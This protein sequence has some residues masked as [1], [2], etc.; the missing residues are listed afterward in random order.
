MSECV[1][2]SILECLRVSSVSSS[3]FSSF[4][5]AAYFLVGCSVPFSVEMEALRDKVYFNCL[6]AALLASLF[7]IHGIICCIS[8]LVYSDKRF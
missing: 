2:K 4:L 5:F 3:V 7:C 8:L 1:S 6:F